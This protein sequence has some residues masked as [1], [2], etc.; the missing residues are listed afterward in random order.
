VLRKKAWL[1]RLT[2]AGGCEWL[3]AVGRNVKTGDHKALQMHDLHS[4]VGEHIIRRVE[5]K[6]QGTL[7]LVS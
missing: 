2:H 7:E 1:V 5:G 3:L 6:R 4:E